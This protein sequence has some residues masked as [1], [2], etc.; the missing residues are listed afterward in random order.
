VRAIVRPTTAGRAFGGPTSLI[1]AAALA[2]AIFVTPSAFAASTGGAPL[3]GVYSTPAA[4]SRIA[5]SGCD[6]SSGR[7]G[8]ARIPLGVIH[9]LRETVVLVGVCVDGKGPY[10][11]VLDTGAATS[12]ISRTFADNAGLPQVGPTGSLGAVGCRVGARLISISHWSLGSVRLARQSVVVVKMS[13]GLSQVD[14]LIGSDVLSRFGAIQINYDSQV[15]TLS[16]REA[17]VPTTIVDQP[18]TSPT[19]PILLKGIDPTVIPLAVVESPLTTVISTTVYLHG[20]PY[21][22]LVDTGAAHSVVSEAVADGLSNTGRGEE[23]YSLGCSVYFTEVRSGPW[24]VGTVPIAPRLIDA[25]SLAGS[26]AVGLLGSDVLFSRTV[27]VIDYN[28][29]RMYV[30]RQQKR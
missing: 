30:G 28:D 27:V 23:G 9:S 18:S 4:L 2:V 11:F 24:R 6:P 7:S 3:A 15:L 17:P 12:V 22:F 10:P 25:T 19:P 5:G 8:Y 14:G 26:T 16:R 20:A 29:G 21:V 13:R 1:V